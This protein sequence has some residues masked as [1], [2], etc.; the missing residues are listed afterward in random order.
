MTNRS[1]YRR[2]TEYQVVTVTANNTLD[3]QPVEIS[4]DNQATWL[5]AA[6]TGSP[7]TTR[8][9]RVL[10]NGS[11]MPAASSPHPVFVRLTDSPETPVFA[12]S[13]TVQFI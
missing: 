9:A 10:L 7:G 8:S 11:N 12:A 13:G 5:T 3:T 4:V 2:S 1:V 6:W